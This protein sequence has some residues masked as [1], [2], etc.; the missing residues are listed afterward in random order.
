MKSLFVFI[1]AILMASCAKMEFDEIAG[2]PFNGKVDPVCS[3]YRNFESDGWHIV[4][5]YFL[6]KDSKRIK[7]KIRKS[8]FEDCWYSYELDSAGDYK[9]KS[10]VENPY[11]LIDTY[12]SKEIASTFT[13]DGDTIRIHRC[14]DY[15]KEKENPKYSLLVVTRKDEEK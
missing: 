11:L 13:Y 8:Y 1:T 9:M 7:S 10:F 2:S 3:T 4:S 12:K 15:P 14:G 5:L 6:D